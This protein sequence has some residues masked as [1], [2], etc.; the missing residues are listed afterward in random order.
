MKVTRGRF[1]AS[2][3]GAGRTSKMQTTFYSINLQGKCHFLDFGINGR[4]ILPVKWVF[5]TLYRML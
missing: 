2:N 4:K 1:Y 5:T 3:G